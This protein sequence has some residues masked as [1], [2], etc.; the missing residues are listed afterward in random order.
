MVIITLDEF[1]QA[2]KMDYEARKIWMMRN[3][4]YVKRWIHEHFSYES[5]KS[6]FE[7]AI[8]DESLQPLFYS[9]ISNDRMNNEDK[10]ALIIQNLKT[11]GNITLILGNRGTGKTVLTYALCEKAHKANKENIWY[12]GLP[13]EFPYFIRGS[14]IDFG[15]IPEGCTVMLE[16]A[17]VQFYNRMAMTRNQRD[18]MRMLPIVRHSKR[19]FIVI[20][21]KLEIADIGF[22]NNASALIYTS[23]VLFQFL[24]KPRE[25]LESRISMFIPRKLGSALYYSDELGLIEFDYPLPRWW[26]EDYSTPYAKI[27]DIRKAYRIAADL[28]F[29]DVEPDLIA[30]QLSLRGI[31]VTELELKRMKELLKRTGKSIMLMDDDSLY[32]TIIAGFDDTPLG[33]KPANKHYNFEQTPIQKMVWDIK[34]DENPEL[35]IKAGVCIN[36]EIYEQIKF[37]VTKRNLIMSVYGE[38][39]SGKTWAAGALGELMCRLKNTKLS[40]DDICYTGDELMERLSKVKENATLIRSE[41]LKKWSTGSGREEQELKNAE[42]TM[43]R[44]HIDFIFVSPD[45]RQHLHHFILETHSIDYHNGV[46]KLIVYSPDEKV[47]GYITLRKPSQELIG[48]IEPKDDSFKNRVIERTS[49]LNTAI[50]RAVEELKQDDLYAELKSQGQRLSYIKRKYPNMTGSEQDDVLFTIEVERIKSLRAG[51]E[52]SSK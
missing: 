13:T 36:K 50:D 19:N 23:P 25:T 14:A 40:I 41:Q 7:Q 22:F 31:T 29:R 37:S 34:M 3:S 30:I 32:N 28:V 18:V 12:F 9:I 35:F 42:E 8:F 10:V 2:K 15:E 4:N 48:M 26:K 45:L 27:K 52:N 17:G 33:E 44:K 39:G 5:A 16:E 11:K 43:R 51:N 6:L 46:S 20:T 21:Q 38:T 1:Q 47:L 24:H 49:S